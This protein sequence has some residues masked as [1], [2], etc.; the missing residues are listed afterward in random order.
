MNPPVVVWGAM[1]GICVAIGLLN[2]VIWLRGHGGD[3][4]SFVFVGVAAFAVAYIGCFELRLMTLESA[5]EATAL[6]R[7]AHAVV[8]VL[9]VALALF[10]HVHLGT[11]RLWLLGAA[12]AA[13][14][15]VLIANFTSDGNIHHLATKSLRTVPFL[16]GHVTVAGEIVPNPSAPLLLLALLLFVAYAVDASVRLWR[17]GDAAQRWRAALVGGSVVLAVAFSLVVSASKDFGIID[18]PYVVTPAFLFIVMAIGQELATDVVRTADLSER[19]QASH[20]QLQLAQERLQLATHAA[21]VGIWEWDRTRDEFHLSAAALE[22]L[23]LPASEKV[24][25][26]DLLDRVHPEDRATLRSAIACAAAGAT[27]VN[28]DVRVTHRDGR[29]RW[30]TLRGGHLP[31]DP[32]ATLLGGVLADVTDRPEHDER[33]SVVANASP[34]GVIM[35][36]RSGVIVFANKKVETVFGYE[37]SELLGKSVDLLVPQASRDRHAQHRRE[38]FAGAV[39]RANAERWEVVGIRKDGS[40]V[41]VEISL[42]QVQLRGEP[43][44]LASVID[45]GWRR[46]AERQLATQRDELAHLSRAAQLGELSGSLAHELNQPLTAIL[47]NAQAAQQLATRGRLDPGTLHEILVDIVSDTRRAGDV[48]QRLRSLLRRGRASM[49]RVDM[50]TIARE[51]LRLMSSD[52]ISRRVTVHTAFTPGLPPVLGDRVQLQQVVLNL[53]LNACEAMADDF[54]SREAVLGTECDAEGRLRFYIVDSG[55]GI[56]EDKLARIFEPFVTTKA[57]GLGLGLSLCRTII[58]HHGGKIAAANN[59]AGGAT[60]EFT[61][62]PAAEQAR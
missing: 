38:Q 25:T 56:P 7:Q 14:V 32:G 23:G 58:E 19:L 31:N 28:A 13:R 21:G 46:D 10:I 29:L 18:W 27:E 34:I 8:F 35:V 1:I 39:S 11:G 37:P 20:G 53:L 41:V 40:D 51:V 36:N 2:L 24:A 5:S 45:Q 47:S 33:L 4:V 26:E 49:E 61:L 44:A 54:G 50:E 59:D 43:V 6:L 9:F 55:P 57:E 52:L 15:A 42:V 48:I 12:L 22:L 16:G 62:Q 60:F 17:K 30:V 3:N